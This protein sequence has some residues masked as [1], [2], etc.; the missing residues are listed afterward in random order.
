MTPFTTKTMPHI[1]RRKSDRE[2][3][4][5]AQPPQVADR[6]VHAKHIVVTRSKFASAISTQGRDV[7]LV[8]CLA[9]WHIAIYDQF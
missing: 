9:G 1:Q 7:R 3:L 5:Y 2:L 6:S 8:I 4:D